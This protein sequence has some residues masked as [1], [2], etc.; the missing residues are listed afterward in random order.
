V[1]AGTLRI[2]KL[3]LLV[4]TGAAAAGKTTAGRA[5]AT[6]EPGVLSLDGDVLAAGAAAI[7]QRD[8]SCFWGYVISIAEEIAD[9]GLAPLISC[10]CRPEQ[11]LSNDLSAFSRLSVLAMTCD[12]EQRVRR[13]ESRPGQ[14]GWRTMLEE[15]NAIDQALRSYRIAEP[16]RF[17]VLDTTGIAADTAILRA[18]DWARRETAER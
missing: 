12:A 13:A 8:F 18:R 11:I 15:H 7:L 16:H 17:T 10:V 5:I 14:V 4:I 1:V 6:A 3:P 9:N 2:V